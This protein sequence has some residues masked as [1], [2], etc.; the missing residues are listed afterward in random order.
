SVTFDWVGTANTGGGA[1]NFSATLNSNGSFSFNYGA[2]N[3]NLNPVIGVSAGANSIYVLSSTNGSAT[4]GG[5]NQQIFTP[6]PGDTYFDIGA[7]EFQGSSADK[8]PPKVVSISSLPANNGTTGLAFTSLTVT[9]SEP[10]DW[11]SASSPA[12]YSLIKADSNGKFNTTGATVIPVT[13][14]YALGSITVTLNL[15]NGVLAA[16]QYQLTLSGTRAIFDQSGNALAGNGTTAGTNYVTVF[17]INRATDIAPVAT[18]QTVSVP[19][20]GSVKVVLA[21]TDTQGNPLTYSIVAAP[22]DGAVS[23]IT[24]GNTLTYTPVANFYGADGFTFQATDPDGKSSQA[25]LKMNVTPVN[26][27]PVAIGQSVNVNHDASQIIVLSGT[28][29]ETQ[30]SQL[31]YTITKQPTHGTLVQNPGNPDAFTYTPAAGYIGGDS[32]NFTVTDTGNPPGSTGNAKTSAAAAVSV[33]VVDPAPVGVADSY[34]TRKGVALNVPVAQGVLANDTDSAGDPL[35]A[36]V[37]TSV[38]HGTLVLNSNGSFTYTPAATFTGTDSFTYLPHGTF[39]TGTA[40]TVTINVTAGVAP[41]PPPPK[42]GSPA[43]AVLA[44]P[45]ATTLLGQ[46]AITESAPVVSNVPATVAVTQPAAVSTPGVVPA[47]KP[48]TSPIM[49]AAATPAAIPLSVTTPTPASVAPDKPTPRPIAPLLAN[50]W[51]NMTALTAMPDPIMLP[52]FTLPGDEVSA[53]MLPATPE[54]SYLPHA[55]SHAAKRFT[56]R[57]PAI[58]TLIDPATGL[59]ADHVLPAPG[60]PAQDQAWLL[61][62][63][64]PDDNLGALSSQIRWDSH[65]T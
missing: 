19:E 65:P 20:D 25:A 64:D 26:Q 4:M 36:T 14:V 17:T 28:D 30:A 13:P 8:T 29:A 33:T 52:R 10:L 38:A 6:Q 57:L 56:E 24:N 27:A 2:G 63:A 7:F 16:G 18:P 45:L 49:Q 58:I 47:A 11:V 51:L 34:S 55:F 3:A 41:P 21:A 31:T 54:I 61:V 53:L 40:T 44:A 59:P 9:V 15:P 46:A 60:P 50:S 5:A 43:P 35:T 1:V 42:H 22:A 62:D 39:K 48:E 12:N 23:A 32:F 37:V